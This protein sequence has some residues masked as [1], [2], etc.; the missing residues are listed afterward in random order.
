MHDENSIP[1]RVRQLE[2]AMVE[3]RSQIK[4]LSEIIAEEREEKIA[5]FTRREK[6]LALLLLFLSVVS[7]GLWRLLG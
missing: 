6:V 5:A 4:R 3:L 7:D 2:L 1:Y